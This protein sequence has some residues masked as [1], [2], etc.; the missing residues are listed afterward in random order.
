M[1]C[2]RTVAVA[3][4][5]TDKEPELQ[6]FPSIIF[7]LTVLKNSVGGNPLIFQYFQLSKKF[8]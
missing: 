5:L 3:K 2:F 7:C 8:G 6:S 4:N 1:L